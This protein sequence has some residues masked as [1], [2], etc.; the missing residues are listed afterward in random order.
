[1]SAV[2][3]LLVKLLCDSCQ[4]ELESLDY[5][6]TLFFTDAT[7]AE[8]QAAAQDWTTDGE[9]HHHCDDCE[10]LELTES[11]KAERARAI[12]PDDVPLFDGGV[13]AS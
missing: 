6:E 9:G 11:A 4:R 12:G 1:M 7:S 3:V 10:P 2:T 13:V 8:A 5:E